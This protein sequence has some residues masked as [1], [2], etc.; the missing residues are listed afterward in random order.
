MV[1]ISELAT[2]HGLSRST[3]LY[4]DRMGV[5][6]PRGRSPKGYRIY[7]QEDAQRLEQICTYRK[8]GI[9]LE[10]IRRL[11]EAPEHALVPILQ[12]R[13]K[14]LEEEMAKLRGQQRLLVQLLQN[15]QVLEELAIMDK[16]TWVALL[17]ASG[18]SDADMDRWHGAF[19]ASDP[20]RH[21]RFL[22]FL[23]LSPEE[24]ARVR[25]AAAT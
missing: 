18:F 9:S 6:S 7:T 8:A 12:L 3:L 15:P 2:R 4:Y 10:A 19:E 24:V 20:E 21:Q 1:R 14:E 13:L 16:A 22:A 11:L 5:L 23:G 25:A 17:R